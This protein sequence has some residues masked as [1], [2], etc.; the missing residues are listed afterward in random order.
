M[1][2]FAHSRRRVGREALVAESDGVVARRGSSA[3]KA[4][5]VVVNRIVVKRSFQIAMEWWLGV[6]PRLMLRGGENKPG[7][8]PTHTA[9][10][11]ILTP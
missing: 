10:T 1:T 11:G 9:R 3:T 2:L 5:S 7:E 8:M 4:A 6:A